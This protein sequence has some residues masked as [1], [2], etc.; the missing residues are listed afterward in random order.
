MTDVPIEEEEPK[1][2][3]HIKKTTPDL[4]RRVRTLTLAL[5]GSSGRLQVSRETTER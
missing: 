5:D 4:D 2:E 3:N 1:K